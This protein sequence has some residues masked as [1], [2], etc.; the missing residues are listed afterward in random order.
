MTDYN[1]EGADEFAFNEVDAPIPTDMD[2]P[3][4]YWMFVMPVAPRK[5]SLGGVW[6]PD[7]ARDAEAFMNSIGRIAAMGDGCFKSAK[8]RQDLGL[9]EFPKVGDFIR[10]AGARHRPFYFKDV[11]M[12]DVRDDQMHSFIQKENIPYY[13]FHR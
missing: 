9:T 13:R 2:K 3:A 6:L 8:L 11:A 7:Q 12:L 5:K 1:F 4:A 10:Y